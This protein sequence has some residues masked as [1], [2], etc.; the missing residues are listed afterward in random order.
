M[1]MAHRSAGNGHSHAGQRRALD[2][3][4]MIFRILDECYAIADYAFTMAG[5]VSTD[6][7]PRRGHAATPAPLL[8][9]RSFSTISAISDVRIADILISRHTTGFGKPS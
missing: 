6:D 1:M 7:F 3:R 4:E 5:A 8:L 2:Q 9:M